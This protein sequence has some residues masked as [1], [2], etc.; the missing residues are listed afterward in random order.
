MSRTTWIV[1]I[2]LCVGLLG[3]LVFIS[4]GEKLNVDNVDL[5]QIQQAAS[6][7]GNIGDHLFGSA[8]PVVTIIEYGDYQC[9]GC[10]N[11][12]PTLR[13]ATENYQDQGVRL[14]FRNFPLTA[15]HPNARAAAAAAEAAG[16]QDKF[17]EMHDLVYSQ[18][19]T[20]SNLDSAART[21]TFVSFADSLGL[22]TEQFK[23]DMTSEA[24]T[25]KIDFDTALARKAGAQGTPA[26]YVNG[27]L[28]SDKRVEDGKISESTDSSLTFVWS[29]AENFEELIIKPALEASKTK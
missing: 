20:W 12:A 3:G 2:A 28:V 6:D 23:T 9:P 15:I 19:S 18:Q 24:V 25:K 17:W 4:R 26:I 8:E 29:T 1:F 27:D 5:Q 11:A 16:L 21:D 10:A 7:N 13:E 22:D 14:V